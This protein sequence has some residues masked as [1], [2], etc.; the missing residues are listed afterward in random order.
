MEL[1]PGAPLK[2]KKK[3][4]WNCDAD[5]H[6]LQADKQMMK[7]IEPSKYNLTA[8]SYL[9]L[10]ICLLHFKFLRPFTGILLSNTPTAD[11]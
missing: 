1:T 5:S 4:S 11:F 6:S 10:N 2:K 3:K 7:E 9:L 8:S